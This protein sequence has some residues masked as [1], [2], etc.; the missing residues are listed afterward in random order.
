VVRRKQG[1]DPRWRYNF[2][3]RRGSLKKGIAGKQQPDV[4][5]SSELSAFVMRM[6]AKSAAD[7]YGAVMEGALVLTGMRTSGEVS[8]R[9]ARVGRAVLMRRAVL[10]N[11]GEVALRMLYLQNHLAGLD[12]LAPRGAVARHQ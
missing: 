8:L 11:P 5:I 7:L 3:S 4:W 1:L 9:S 10:E 12:S 2:R 6:L